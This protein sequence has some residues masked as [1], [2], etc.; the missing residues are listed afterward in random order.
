M[1]ACQERPRSKSESGV[2]NS[3]A[4]LPRITASEESQQVGPTAS[5]AAGPSIRKFRLGRFV[6]GL[7]LSAGGMIIILLI[8]VSLT[9]VRHLSSDVALPVVALAVIFGVMCLGGG[10]GLMAT[11]SSGY[12]EQEFDR[13]IR[14]D[15]TASNTNEGPPP[16]AITE[17]PEHSGP[18]Q[19]SN[20]EA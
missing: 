8:A 10:F 16:R 1:I 5:S 15:H 3:A 4:A 12:D 7:L 18:R 20:Q 6:A 14:G 13:L 2:A 11:A 17:T 19:S 9:S